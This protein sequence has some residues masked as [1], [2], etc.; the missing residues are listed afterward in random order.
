M[1]L[2]GAD[3]ELAIAANSAIG[4]MLVFVA[5]VLGSFGGFIFYLARKARLAALEDMAADHTLLNR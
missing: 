3:G 5:L 2:G 4:L 1:C